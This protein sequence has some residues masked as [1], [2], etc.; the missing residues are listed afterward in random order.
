[1]ANTTSH[2]HQRHWVKLRKARELMAAI[3][4]IN[5]PNLTMIGG[6]KADAAARLRVKAAKV[7]EC[8]EDEIEAILDEYRV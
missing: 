1:M 4:R 8:R 2:G 3:E 6:T 7:L 5:N